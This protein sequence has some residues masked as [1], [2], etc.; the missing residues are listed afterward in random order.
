MT[1]PEPIRICAVDDLV[2]GEGL[3]VTT[4]S[5]P[6]AVFLTE[7][8][9]IH[10]VDDTCPHQDASLA[11]GWVEDC[12]VECPLH[13]SRFDLRSGR[14]DAPPAKKPIRVHVVSVDNGSVFVQLS[15]EAPNLPP[16]VAV[17]ASS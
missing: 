14:V 5:P 12:W 7:S 2:E 16:G 10:A 8:G 1:T 13:E 15:T 4:V 11:D 9:E 6:I 3:R 17:E